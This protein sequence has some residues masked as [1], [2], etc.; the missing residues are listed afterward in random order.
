M[1]KNKEARA[2]FAHRLKKLREERDISQ[3]ELAEIMKIHAG[4]VSRFERGV[5]SPT[6][7]QIIFLSDYFRTSTDYLLGLTDWRTRKY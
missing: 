4:T 2:L 7:D 6:L 5:T 1:M 3:R